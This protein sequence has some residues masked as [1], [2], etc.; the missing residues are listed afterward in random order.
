V[1][2][3]K[4]M[5][6]K[7]DEFLND[8]QGY[9]MV[10]LKDSRLAKAGNPITQDEAKNIKGGVCWCCSPG[11]LGIAPNI[12]FDTPSGQT[13]PTRPGMPSWLVNTQTLILLFRTLIFPTQ[14]AVCR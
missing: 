2:K 10:F 4:T 11:D 14:A 13:C 8:F 12:E 9:A 7:L 6:R 3:D 1:R 5:S